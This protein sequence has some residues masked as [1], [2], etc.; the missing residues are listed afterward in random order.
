MQG[1]GSLL[2]LAPVAFEALQSVLA[3]ALS[4][5]SLFSG[6]SFGW[7]CDPFSRNL[8]STKGMRGKGIRGL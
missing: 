4:G 2:G 8:I 1:L 7:G 3:T 5:F 6:V